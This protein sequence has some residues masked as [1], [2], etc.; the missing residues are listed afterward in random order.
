[1]NIP[2]LAIEINRSLNDHLM[3]HFQELRKRLKNLRKLRTKKIFTFDTIRDD[4]AFHNGGRSEIQFNIGKERQG[5]TIRYGL[6]FS[7]EPSRALPNPMILRNKIERL[8]I[9][10]EESPNLFINYSLWYH[11]NRLRIDVPRHPFHIPQEAIALGNFIFL[12]KEEISENISIHNI[13]NTFDEMLPIYE[14]IEGE[15]DD[16]SITSNGISETFSF[17]DA[18]RS[19]PT[20]YEVAINTQTRHID[21]L[22]TRIQQRLIEKLKLEYGENNVTYENPIYN[23]RIDVVVRARDG[24]YF[25]E[26]KVASSISK[27]IRDS[28][29]QLL[30][31][32]YSNFEEH[33]KKLFIVSNYDIDYRTR[34]YLS[35]LR[36][37]FGL[38]IDYLS[39]NV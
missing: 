14:V 4:W 12:G 2:E 22:H 25:Y 6:A 27:V 8:N 38:P 35:F 17:Q 29:G 1:M 30:E 18:H 37:H 34:R 39:I 33:A 15:R 19:L 26:V 24:F 21:S 20:E 13:L 32:A 36:E 31:Y 16:I 10:I 28:I 9:L 11:S 23:K 5:Q 7:L 3:V